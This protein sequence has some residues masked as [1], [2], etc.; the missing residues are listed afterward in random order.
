MD[1]AKII[2]LAG[3]SFQG[4]SLISLS[5]ANTLKFSGVITTDMIRNVLKI[6]DSQQDY[7]GISTYMLTKDTLAQQME[8]VSDMTRK[9]ISIYQE[10]GEHMIIEG[11]HFSRNFMQWAKHQGFYCLCINNEKDLRERIELKKV[12]RSRLRGNLNDSFESFSFE[13]S[14]YSKYQDRIREIHSNILEDARLEGF[15]IVNFNELKLGIERSLAYI[16]KLS[17]R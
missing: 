14:N 4:K 9:I 12:T 16:K 10:R 13:N 7:W 15:E 11:M 2:I 3:G 6:L 1:S 17:A 8:I 5:L